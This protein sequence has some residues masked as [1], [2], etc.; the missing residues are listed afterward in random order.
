VVG[1]GV[2]PVGDRLELGG[3]VAALGALEHGEMAH[4]VVGGATVPVLLTRRGIYG[5]PC[6][7]P[8]H[9]AVPSGNEADA[10][11]DVQGLAHRVG[12]P[13]GARAGVNRTRLTIIRDGSFPR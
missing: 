3:A 8:D 11:G 7:H 12:V 4:H 1:G 10:V 13:V 2:L 6:S 5:V 9:R